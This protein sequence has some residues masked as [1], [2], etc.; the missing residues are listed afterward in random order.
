M[1]PYR[2]ALH[3]YI[4]TQGMAPARS[5]ESDWCSHLGKWELEYR[6]SSLG[7]RKSIMLVQGSVDEDWQFFLG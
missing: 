3:P 1:S 4:F 7:A 2:S 6:L 5:V